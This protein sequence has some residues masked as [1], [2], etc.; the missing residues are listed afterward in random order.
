MFEYCHSAYEV[1]YVYRH[2]YGLPV[3]ITAGRVAMMTGPR[4][5]VVSMP[6]GIGARVFEFVK[7]AETAPIVAD[8]RGRRWGFLVYPDRAVGKR[9]MELLARWHVIPV[10]PGRSILLPMSDSGIGFRWVRQPIEGKL[11]LPSRTQVVRW[12][13]TQTSADP[14]IRV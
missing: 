7:R 2:I 9:R 11:Q 12:A 10:P 1:A 3:H 4:L 8:P 5:G 14:P 6:A 13:Q